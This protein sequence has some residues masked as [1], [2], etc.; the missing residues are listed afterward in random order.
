MSRDPVSWFLI[1]PGWDV[2]GSD[3]TA[4]GT[5]H[6][7]IGDTGID[8]FDGL[9]VSPGQ[10]R[11]SKYVPSERVGTIVEGRIEVDVSADEF[12]RLGEHAE[13]PPSADIR[14]DTT[15]IEPDR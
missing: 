7:V 3:G 15:H 1:E 4:L 12:E 8:I 11:S 14:A 6:E 9:A 13:Q 10:L 2:V 5:V